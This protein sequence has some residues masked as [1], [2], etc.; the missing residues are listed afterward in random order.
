MMCEDGISEHTIY[1]LQL[2][3]VLHGNVL[4]RIGGHDPAKN[5]YKYFDML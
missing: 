2:R 3:P 1:D 4:A 5:T